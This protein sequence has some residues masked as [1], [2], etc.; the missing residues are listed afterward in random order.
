MS[1]RAPHALAAPHLSW[2]GIIRL[3]LVQTALGSIIVLMTTT[4]NRIMVVELSLAAM[5]PGALVALHYVI[6]I[7]RPRWGYA[8]DMSGR[9][10]PFIIGGMATLS[11]GGV[12]GTLGT[13]IM[14]EHAF[15]G[16][17]L[18][19]VAFT[20]IGIGV[21]AAGTNLLA[22]LATQVAPRRRPAAASIVWIMMIAGFVV[23]AGTTGALLDP[24]SFE[25]LLV[26]VASV[27]VLAFIVASLAVWGIER[28]SGQGLIAEPR[29]E[30]LA[31]RDFFTAF[32]EVWREAEARR[33]TIFVFISMF[34]YSAQ[35]LILEPF[36]G[37]VFH[38]TPGQSTSL[39]G[40]QHGGVLLGMIMVALAGSAYGRGRFGS[41]RFWA[42]TG[43]LASALAFVGLTFAASAGTGY[44]LW[45]NV[46]FLGVAN[47]AFAVAAIGSM[48]G[49]ANSGRAQREGT[50]MGLWGAAQAIA[51]GLGG[52]LGTV[53]VDLMRALVDDP[54]GAYA[55]V[56]AVEAVLFIVSALIALRLGAMVPRNAGTGLHKNGFLS[57]R[58]SDDGNFP[59]K[60]LAPCPAE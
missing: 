4:L 6:Q 57:D 27:A 14:A 53:A 16:G 36:A 28:P 45:A 10:A 41:M 48:M 2:L 24:F 30:S 18:T 12:L 58:Q 40:M 11:L 20:M 5:V 3:G 32:R 9:R 19:V 49:L 38:L 8:S 50:R 42:V 44:P 43:C 29:A 59:E 25:R 15:A 26:V 1:G 56:F 39:G 22:L 33:F 34:A 54:A 7:S 31:K 55:T 60:G 47:G 13:V 23:T 51:F 37:L 52:F 21:G 35:D 17:L 46:F